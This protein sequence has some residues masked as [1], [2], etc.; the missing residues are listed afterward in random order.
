[1]PKLVTISSSSCL[2]PTYVSVRREGVL[3]VRHRSLHP[4]HKLKLLR[5]GREIVCESERVWG[6]LP[7]PISRSPYHFRPLNFSRSL[8]KQLLQRGRHVVMK[9]FCWQI[10]CGKLRGGSNST[11]PSYPPVPD[12]SKADYRPLSITL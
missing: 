11:L 8:F 12:R 10:D 2:L 5:N 4:S 7:S 9:I 1:M 3:L 6:V